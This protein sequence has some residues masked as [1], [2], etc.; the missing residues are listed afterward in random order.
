MVRAAD[1]MATARPEPVASS[2]NR[3]AASTSNQ[4]MALTQP[5]ID[6]SR[7]KL[8]ERSKSRRLGRGAR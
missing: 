4:R 6:H 7:R 1:T 3:A 8:R 2:V 5:P